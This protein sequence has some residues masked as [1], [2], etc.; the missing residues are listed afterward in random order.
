MLDGGA[1]ATPTAA[2][3]VKSNSTTLNLPGL[4]PSATKDPRNLL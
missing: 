1:K 2:A 3:P 4:L